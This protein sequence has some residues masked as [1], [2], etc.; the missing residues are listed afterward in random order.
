MKTEIESALASF[1]SAALTQRDGSVTSPVHSG[2][3]SPDSVDATREAV[4]CLVE[5][6]PNV[7]GTLGTATCSIVVSSPAAAGNET[8]HNA[9]AKFIRKLFPAAKAPNLP[10][11]TGH[12]SDH[13][14]TASG[15]DLSCTGYALLGTD[16]SPA[17][18]RWQSNLRITL[19]VVLDCDEPLTGSGDIVY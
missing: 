8:A 10:P 14:Q 6:Q 2:S 11:N 18:G 3:V 13:L 15:G 9:L 17:D 1:I 5:D 16:G 7:V 4:I 19:G 12:I